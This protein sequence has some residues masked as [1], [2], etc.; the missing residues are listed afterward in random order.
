MPLS[1]ASVKQ[2]LAGV[3]FYFEIFLAVPTIKMYGLF[4]DVGIARASQQ[5]HQT[6][7]V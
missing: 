7:D 2:N 6:V 1:H 3:C 5:K 4:S